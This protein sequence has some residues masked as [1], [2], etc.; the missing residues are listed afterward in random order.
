MADDRASHS[1]TGVAIEAVDHI[2][3]RVRRLDRSLAFYRR[4]GFELHHRA[5]DDAVAVVRNAAG[6]ELNLIFNANAGAEDKNLLMDLP[7][8]YSGYTHMALRVAR[9]ADVLTVLAAEGIA[10]SQ[11]PV[12]FGD[13]AVSVF[14]RD[15]DRNV[16]ELRGRG[17]DAAAVAGVRRYVPDG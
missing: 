5:K 13:G 12:T 11:G 1:S 2:G 15:P 17:Q 3:I 7:E 8:K 6:V 10:I 9:I 16:I 14:I 4:L